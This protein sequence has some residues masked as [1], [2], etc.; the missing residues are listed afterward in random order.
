MKF[1]FVDVAVLAKSA[2]RNG[3]DPAS[4][5]QSYTFMVRTTSQRRIEMRNPV[6]LYFRGRQG[7]TNR[8]ESSH[9]AWCQGRGILRHC[10][11]RNHVFQPDYIYFPTIGRLGRLDPPLYSKGRVGRYS[12]RRVYAQTAVWGR[13]A[14]SSRKSISSGNAPRLSHVTPVANIIS[15][16][17]YC[18]HYGREEE[19][20]A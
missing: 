20:T 5:W 8:Q 14:I 1:S 7:L 4:D 10:E 6:A 16:S 15:R 19:M 12:I 11:H 3:D 17:Q 13:E 9:P 2:R 18:L